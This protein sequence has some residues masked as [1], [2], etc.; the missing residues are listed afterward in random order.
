MSETMSETTTEGK[1]PPV[2]QWR[3]RV[4][5]RG[6]VSKWRDVTAGIGVSIVPGSNRVDQVEFRVKPEREVCDAEIYVYGVASAHY[7]RCTLDL[8][9]TNP[10]HHALTGYNGM[11][12]SWA[13]V[14]QS[15]LDAAYRE[16]AHFIALLTR[17][18]DE[19]SRWEADPKNPG[20][21]L[22]YIDAPCGQLSW[23]VADGDWDLF[24]HVR[25]DDVRWDGHSTE[26]KY[27]R[28]DTLFALASQ[29]ADHA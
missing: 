8:G 12:V 25:H 11:G 24:E 28:L 10:D 4:G 17:L 19:W 27:R 6:H 5:V 13:G 15:A 2:Y 1:P 18:Y 26:E 14:P 20:Y 23:H 22:V 29:D 16:R 7:A 3:Y 9:H 21:R